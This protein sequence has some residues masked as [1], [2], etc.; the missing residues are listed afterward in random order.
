M[1]AVD[2]AVPLVTFVALTAVGMDLT[3]AHFVAVR[4]RPHILAVGLLAPVLLLPPLAAGLVRLFQPPPHVAI[5]L[6]LIS[7]CPIGGISNT[8][9]FLAGASPALSVVLTTISAVLA[10][11]TI[12]GISWGLE[13]WTG[14][15]LGF[16]APAALPLQLLVMV[17]LPVGI[18]MAI[19]A[20]WGHAAGARRALVQRVAFI[21]L[22]IVLALI[23]TSDLERFLA[24]L[25]DSVP[26]ALTFI[27]SSFG[28]G[29]LSTWV[30]AASPADR[31]TVAVEFATRN[32]GVASTIAV[33]LLG[34][35]AF[36][37]FGATYFLSE[38]PVMLLAVW[39]FRRRLPEVQ[40]VRSASSGTLA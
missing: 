15:S 20:R 27:A 29:W 14:Q 31:F 39:L 21:A 9:S 5:G 13:R 4:R 28:F 2:L 7:A 35:P 23:I 34:Q 1:T 37:F 25:Y 16:E 40:R 32:V 22:A 30:V 6:L 18:G 12:P 38:I 17:V 19:R 24:G 26:L 10:F 8:Y 36:A 3:P 33:T 11:A